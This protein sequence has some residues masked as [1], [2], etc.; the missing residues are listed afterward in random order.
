[1]STNKVLTISTIVIVLSII[2]E[3]LFVHHHIHYWWHGLIGFDVIYG[4]IGCLFLIV[5]A[6]GLGK[7]FI[8]RSEQYY[9]GGEDNNE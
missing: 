2:V 5:V 3:V 7:L 1:M 9:G 8:Q 4:A 6:K